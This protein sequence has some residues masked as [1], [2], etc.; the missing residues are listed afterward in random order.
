M[1]TAFLAGRARATFGRGAALAV[2]TYPA[3]HATACGL[4]VD[5]DPA[6]RVRRRIA[7]ETIDRGVRTRLEA[8]AFDLATRTARLARDGI[9]TTLTGI[10]TVAAATELSRST[11]GTVSEEVGYAFDA[12]ALSGGGFAWT[13]RCGC[14]WLSVAVAPE[15]IGVTIQGRNAELTG[16]VGIQLSRLKDLSTDQAGSRGTYP[17]CT[18]SELT[19]R[20]TIVAASARPLEGISALLLRITRCDCCDPGERSPLQ[21][22]RARYVLMPPSLWR[23]RRISNHPWISPI[24]SMSWRAHETNTGIT[25]STRRF[26]HSGD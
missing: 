24:T 25:G 2:A 8:I 11:L 10:A 6:R 18:G 1:R 14:A 16:V 22:L 4:I 26:F 3:G 21:S 17:V 13:G 15:P 9:A 7:V 20:L 5:G 23:F 12:D 19:A